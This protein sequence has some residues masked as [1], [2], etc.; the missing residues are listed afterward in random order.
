MFQVFQVSNYGLFSRVVL[1]AASDM[2][3]VTGRLSGGRI[4]I[5]FTRYRYH[6]P[7]GE[8]V[9][10]TAPFWR[11]YRVGDHVDPADIMLMWLGRRFFTERV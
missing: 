1:I 7:I 8:L 6:I 5:G 9:S 11:R 10:F 3:G 2:T 4:T